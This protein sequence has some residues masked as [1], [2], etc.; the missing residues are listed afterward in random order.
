MR[1]K[2]CL[3]V[4]ALTTSVCF[5]QFVP[6]PKLL[7]VGTSTTPTIVPTTATTGALNYIPE[8][9]LV[10]CWNST[11][12]QAADCV[13]NSGSSVP[14]PQG[15]GFTYKGAFAPNTA[16]NSYDV[17]T[18]AG[19]TYEAP[20]AFTSNSAFN[21]SN[22][23][24][25]AAQGAIGNPGTNAANPVFS[26][27]ANALSSGATPTAS[28]SGTYPN[29]AVALGI[30]VGQPGQNGT[31]GN[32]GTAATVTVGSVTTGNAGTSVS[33]TNSGSSSAAVFNFT[34]PQGAQGLQGP[35]VY[36]SAGIADST[37][38]AWK[39]VTSAD[40]QT[41]I[42]SGVYDAS[43]AATTAQNNSLQKANNLSDLASVPTAKTNLGF[44]VQSCDN[45]GA[46]PAL[47]GACTTVPTTPVEG[48]LSFN[49]TSKSMILRAGGMSGSV[50]RKI[51]TGLATKNVSNTTTATSII[52][53]TGNGSATMA[54]G[55]WYPGRALLMNLDGIYSTTAATALT[56]TIKLGTQ[57]IA[58]GTIPATGLGAASTNQRMNVDVRIVCL[59]ISGTTCT[60][61]I[62]GALEYTVTNQVYRGNADLDNNGASFTFDTSVAQTLDVQ[63]A[64]TAAA[65]GNTYTTNI[66]TI[67]EQ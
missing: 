65:T 19:Q 29:L 61:Q 39:T 7:Y 48:Q 59:S 17:V 21:A 13:F 67:S 35:T 6:P 12:G 28:V 22:W 47:I 38:S 18:Y 44:N 5:G 36:P 32:P 41:A 16:Y 34:I 63:V 15:Q 20:T 40:M 27:T 43:G 46:Y 53:A 42:G 1:R 62:G 54:A 11:L 30:P 58:T 51:F 25:W 4:F 60:A 37:G 55:Y 33:V 64:F 31:Q 8:P 14:G 45:T 9:I 57:T 49:Q 66:A 3:F 23:S 52:P 10:K 50:S 2:V 56:A 26:F 24:L